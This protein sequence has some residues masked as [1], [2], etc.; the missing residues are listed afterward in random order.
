MRLCGRGAVCLCGRRAVC[1]C[2]RDA[3]RLCGG[4][5]CIYV[6]GDGR[7]SVWEGRSVSD[8][9]FSE[10]SVNVEDC[11]HVPTWTPDSLEKTHCQCWKVLS[12][13]SCCCRL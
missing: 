8:D 7:V 12:Y 13:S 1:L 2:G 3:V 11:V 5:Q 4:M 6:V 10:P 9:L